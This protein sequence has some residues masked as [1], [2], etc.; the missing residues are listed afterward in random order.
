MTLPCLQ[1][2]WPLLDL[3]AL[4]TVPLAKPWVAALYL[5]K[6]TP[7]LVSFIVIAML[8][9]KKEATMNLNFIASPR[10]H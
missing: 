4:Y 5:T 3:V 9:S 10:S 8:T 2:V 1:Y 7:L 6:Q